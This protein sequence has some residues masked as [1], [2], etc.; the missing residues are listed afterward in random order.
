MQLSQMFVGIAVNV[1]AW[2]MARKEGAGC[3]FRYHLFYLAATMYA[4]YALLFA[5]FFYQRYIKKAPLA[6]SLE[7]TPTSSLELKQQ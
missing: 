2:R 6:L 7:D 1:M 5:N 4:S 3:Q